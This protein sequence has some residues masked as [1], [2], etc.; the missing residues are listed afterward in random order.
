M[1]GLCGAAIHV[2]RYE[3]PAAP[4]TVVMLHGAGGCG[5][6]LA[7][8]GSLLHAHDYEIVLPDLPGYGLSDVPT[9]LFTYD[10]WVDCIVEL[11]N[12]ESE[13][14]GR[15]VVLFGTSLGGYLAYLA[16][17]KGRQAAGVI[18]TTL[19]DPR[20][21]IVRKQFSKNPRLSRVLTPLLTPV[22]AALVG[23]LRLPIRWFAKMERISNNPDLARLLCADPIAGGNRV[24]L[25]F[26]YSLL[27]IKPALDPADFDVCPVLLAH[28]G[29]DRWI[30]LDASRPV[31]DRI[32]GPKQLV[33]FE[34]RPPAHR[35]AG[36]Q[37]IG[38][39]GRRLFGKPPARRSRL[40]PGCLSRSSFFCLLF[41]ARNPGGFRQPSSDRAEEDQP[42]RHDGHDGKQ[43]L[44][45]ALRR[46]RRAAVV[47]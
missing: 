37:S 34:L 14:S 38:G 33:T 7:P 35:R 24:P 15:P 17:A 1:V 27:R 3:S 8:F 22:A 47:L 39:G 6:L 42:P 25:G 18:A 29:A 13:R 20:L 26:L 10:R 2:D 44:G 46:V 11:V 40:T 30:T 28:P 23:G 9:E 12:A 32:K 45:I 5:R 19:G 4:L 43:K 31:F 41:S 36:C 21:P 16:A